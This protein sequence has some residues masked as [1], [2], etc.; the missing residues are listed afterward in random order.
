[1]PAKKGKV[2]EV[3]PA[4]DPPEGAC[5]FVRFLFVQVC[6]LQERERERERQREREREMERE[7]FAFLTHLC[8]EQIR[9]MTR[10]KRTMTKMLSSLS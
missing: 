9:T 4:N 5:M 3:P 10:T 1:M 2:Q 6:F 8:C 7:L